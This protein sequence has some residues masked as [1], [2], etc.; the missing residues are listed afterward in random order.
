MRPG[1]SHFGTTF[2]EL[3]KPFVLRDDS[4]QF[5]RGF[6]DAAPLVRATYTATRP[7]AVKGMHMLAPSNTAVSNALV[8]PQKTLAIFL[9]LEMLFLAKVEHGCPSEDAYP[10]G[11]LDARTPSPFCPVHSSPPFCPPSAGWVGKKE[12]RVMNIMLR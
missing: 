11:H 10:T 5:L 4:F 8:L 2:A 9:V 6:A 12:P 1:L 7:A 3:P